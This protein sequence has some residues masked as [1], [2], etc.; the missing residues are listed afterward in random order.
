MPGVFLRILYTLLRRKLLPYPTLEELLE[1]R[2]EAALTE[3]LGE[4]IQ[5]RLGS[6]SSSD[7][8]EAWRLF[9]VFS[10]PNKTGTRTKQTK[11]PEAKK[12]REKGE[13]SKPKTT[14]GKE[15]EMSAALVEDDVLSAETS[16]TA[17]GTDDSTKLYQSK[18]SEEEKDFKRELLNV[19]S[20][21][22]DLHERVKK[23]VANLTK[24]K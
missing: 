21:L 14:K 9:R 16:S 17:V 12:G 4:Q 3:E 18:A 15:P 1:R 22:A 11:T 6:A 24:S 13:K 5:V 7:L 19:L 2:C 10:R 23:Y 8:L 20:D